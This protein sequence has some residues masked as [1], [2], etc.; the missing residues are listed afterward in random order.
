ME[1]KTTELDSGVLAYLRQ[2][3]A[4]YRNGF[5]DDEMK[6]VFLEGVFEEIQGSEVKLSLMKSTCFVIEQFVEQA[7]A[8]QLVQILQAFQTRF[9]EVAHS[10]QGCHVL[11][12]ALQQVVILWQS[13][14]LDQTEV[15]PDL[16]DVIIKSSDWLKQDDALTEWMTDTYATH[17]TRSIIETLGGIMLVHQHHNKESK[18]SVVKQKKD[19]LLAKE[20][21][22]KKFLLRLKKLV[23]LLSNLNKQS[24]A[25]ILT[26]TSGCPCVCTLI[27]VLSL[28]LPKTLKRLCSQII[29]TCTKDNNSTVLILCKDR[30][31]SRA[32]EAIFEYGDLQS[33]L[34]LYS[35]FAQDQDTFLELACHPV[36]NFV[37]QKLISSNSLQDKFDETFELLV[38]G[39]EDI[40]AENKYGVV[41]KLAEQCLKHKS[42][43][44]KFLDTLMKTF[45]CEEE[46]QKKFII[47]LIAS[48]S[49]YDTFITSG[50]KIPDLTN[51]VYHGALLLQTLFKFSK[52]L[53]VSKSITVMPVRHS[54]S[55]ACSISGSHVIDS[56]VSSQ[57]IKQ[58]WK[59]KWFDKMKDQFHVIACDKYGSRVIDNIW[60]SADVDIKTMLAECLAPQADVLL[61]DQYGK[62][63]H[64]NF[65]LRQFIHRRT[66]WDDF[67]ARQIKK[68]KVFEDLFAD[69]GK[70]KKS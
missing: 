47:P 60:K 50:K 12:K 49:T 1:T 16:C 70:K 29:T 9:K 54:V 8:E 46:D 68:R 69:S 51:I 45:H 27:Q 17:V 67:H 5:D 38:P 24:M 36:A 59:T 3:D 63:L 21:L 13:H 39:I 23:T 28:R 11:Q 33:C 57:T 26:D 30:T 66:E 35:I 34:T 6:Q 19:I 15:F 52:T 4:T 42:Y 44:V 56:F 61:A 41:Q 10:Q 58:K 43:Q 31:G 22:P 62:H 20:S 53:L 18:I 64:R 14:G 37:I 48:F 32:I 2:A 25:E 7:Q 40:F 55:L 65:G